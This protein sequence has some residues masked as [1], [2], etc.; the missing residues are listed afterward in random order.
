MMHSPLTRE[1]LDSSLRQY[2]P[3]KHVLVGERDREGLAR[4]Q[5]CSI[6]DLS[7]FLGN[8]E[9]AR[10]LEDITER[11]QN[12]LIEGTSPHTRLSRVYQTSYCWHLI[13]HR[14]E[15]LQWNA[16]SGVYSARGWLQLPMAPLSDEPCSSK[17]TWKSPAVKQITVKVVAGWKLHEE[18]QQ[19]TARISDSILIEKDEMPSMR[20]I[21]YPSS[22]IEVLNACAQ[23]LGVVNTVASWSD[24]PSIIA[25]GG[26]I[27]SFSHADLVVKILET[28][29][30][31]STSAPDASITEAAGAMRAEAVFSSA[32]ACK[33]EAARSLATDESRS[34]A[35]RVSAVVL[36]KDSSQFRVPQGKTMSEILADDED[37]QGVVPL[38]QEVALLPILGALLDMIVLMSEHVCLVIISGLLTH[39]WNCVGICL[40]CG[41]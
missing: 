13:T 2:F 4:R 8:P 1:V 26:G 35:A 33:A 3:Y 27:Q 9:K 30:Q 41:G 34:E 17:V 5:I 12:M 18:A 28:T 6:K 32:E 36:T 14:Y 37:S 10:S 29:D 22:N 19:M 31:N 20:P 16:G 25:M 23:Q 15:T 24:L 21:R 11:T 38:L 40:R 7:R 39:V